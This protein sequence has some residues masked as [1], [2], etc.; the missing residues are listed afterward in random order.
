MPRKPD[1]DLTRRQRAVLAFIEAFYRRE[2]L[3]PTVR[4]IAQHF[5]VSPPSALSFL[6]YLEK[7][8]Y[9]S[10]SEKARGIQLKAWKQPVDTVPVLGRVAAGSPLLAQ[11]NLEGFLRVDSGLLP[12]GEVFALRVKGDS[13]VEKGIGDGDY[14]FVRKQEAFDTGDVV[15][16]VVDDEATVKVLEEQG[17]VIRLKPANARYPSLFFDQKDHSVR[18]AGKVVGVFRRL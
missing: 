2:G 5:R 9:I 16:A 6:R 7:K 1:K 4:E 18:L 11:E 14:V 10:R 12:T 8:G 17:R 13:M 15:V 3:P